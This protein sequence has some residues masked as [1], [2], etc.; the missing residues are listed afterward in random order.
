MWIREVEIETG[1]T[2]K[3]IRY[4]EQN[5]LIQTVKGVNGYREYDEETVKQLLEIKKLR[6]L[7]FSVSEIA[8][9]QNDQRWEQIVDEKISEIQD[10]IKAA[11][12]RKKLLEQVKKGKTLSELDVEQELRK[13]KIGIQDILKKNSIFGVANLILFVMVHIW[14]ISK[15]NQTKKI[16]L[17]NTILLAQCMVTMIFCGWQSYLEHESRKKG[18]LLRQQ[19]W[20]EKVFMLIVFTLTYAVAGQMEL[21]CI[22]IFGVRIVQIY[23]EKGHLFLVA[24]DLMWEVLRILFAI[25][26]FMLEILIIVLGFWSTGRKAGEF[27]IDR[28][29][30]LC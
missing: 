24:A 25:G 10:E 22:G 19:K 9:Y 26:F 27:L 17:S 12:R 15:W 30:V 6:L 13:K 4:Y 8:A 7:E 5:G 2:R 20:F 23:Q 3:A 21:R 29:K 11:A 16:E 18:I 28:R 1:L 14:L